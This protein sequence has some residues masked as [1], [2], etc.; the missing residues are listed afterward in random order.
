MIVFL[1]VGGGRDKE[2]MVSSAKKI[3]EEGGRMSSPYTNLAIEEGKEGKARIS[4]SSTPSRK[5]RSREPGLT[6][7]EGGEKEKIAEYRHAL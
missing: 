2:T 4:A 1:L 7:I 5:K 6:I 3:G